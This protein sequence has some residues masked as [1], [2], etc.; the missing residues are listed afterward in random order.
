LENSVLVVEADAQ[1][2]AD[3]SIFEEWLKTYVVPIFPR[4]KDKRV[5]TLLDND[6]MPKDL[7]KLLLSEEG[8]DL[9]N[10]DRQQATF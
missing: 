4:H 10:S 1:G 9:F 7:Q 2:M 3:R 6:L 8:S 5:R